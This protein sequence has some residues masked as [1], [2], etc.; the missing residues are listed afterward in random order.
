MLVRSEPVSLVVFDWR[1]S[2][3]VY[4]LHLL[5][6]PNLRPSNQSS[7]SP[8]VRCTGYGRRK[9]FTAGFPTL[10]EEAQIVFLC[11]EQFEPQRLGWRCCRLTTIGYQA[12]LLIASSC[13]LNDAIFGHKS[14]SRYVK[15]RSIGFEFGLKRSNASCEK[16]V[17]D[18]P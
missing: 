9:S 17:E 8:T 1:Q 4:R 2:T 13:L 5:Q 15:Y 7:S 12:N 3:E 11:C 18:V 14:S 6:P 10:L 16:K